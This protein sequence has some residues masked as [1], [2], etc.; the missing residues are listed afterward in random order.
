MATPRIPSAVWSTL[1]PIPVVKKKGLAE[2]DN[3]YG[4]FNG[5]N[6]QVSLDAENIPSVNAQTFFH[7]LTHVALWD[8]GVHY[9]LTHEQTESICDAVGTYFGGMMLAGCL[10]IK[11]PKA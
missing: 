4:M 2:N 8:S 7:E 5:Q 1:G 9:T 6:R 10:T 11:A 3:A